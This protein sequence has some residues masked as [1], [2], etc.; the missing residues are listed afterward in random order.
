MFIHIA[1]KWLVFSG[2]Y[3]QPAMHAGNAATSGMRYPRIHNFPD[4]PPASRGIGAAGTGKINC[5]LRSVQIHQ[6]QTGTLLTWK[7]RVRY[8]T[9]SSETVAV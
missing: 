9:I 5:T 2:T 4:V 7:G 1:A 6:T 3:T 8:E